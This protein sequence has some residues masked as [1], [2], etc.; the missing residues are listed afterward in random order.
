M[1]I[2]KL[3]LMAYPLYKYIKNSLEKDH[4]L[5]SSTTLATLNFY[6]FYKSLIEMESEPESVNSQEEIKEDVYEKVQSLKDTM[7]QV[8][9][10]G[11]GEDSTLR[12]Q[13]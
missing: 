10:S 8:V 11:V 2:Q 7:T 3:N 13:E 4:G 12:P 1:T 9:H 5:I 6:L